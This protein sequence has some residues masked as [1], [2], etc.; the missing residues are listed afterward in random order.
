M[1]RGNLGDL[2]KFS[3]RGKSQRGAENEDGGGSGR[4]FA[5]DGGERGGS[6][7]RWQIRA[8]SRRIRPDPSAGAGFIPFCNRVDQLLD[9]SSHVGELI[10]PQPV[11]LFYG[12]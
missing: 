6:R 4:N 1:K 2:V 11:Q 7:R 9:A 12:A 5:G 3:P 10:S 8:G